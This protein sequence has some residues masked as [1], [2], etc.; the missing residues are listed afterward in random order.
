[1]PIPIA[2]I[3][4]DIAA[5]A[6]LG[7]YLFTEQKQCGCG[8]DDCHGLKNW[9]FFVSIVLFV[10]AGFHTIIILNN[11]FNNCLSRIPIISDI[12]YKVSENWTDIYVVSMVVIW[13]WILY[14]I[15]K[16]SSIFDCNKDLVIAC[17]VFVGYSIIICLLYGFQRDK[18]TSFS[19]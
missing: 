2:H 7:Y 14:L 11:C 16:Y 6:G 12:L 5:N 19:I 18:I 4:L 9:A 1:M 3:V 10:Y 13:S 17:E 15:I 8:G